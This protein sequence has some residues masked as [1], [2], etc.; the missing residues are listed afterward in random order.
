MTKS[1]ILESKSKIWRAFTNV[2][3]LTYM[4]IQENVEV[5]YG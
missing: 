5:P 4:L 3:N 1:K 2:A